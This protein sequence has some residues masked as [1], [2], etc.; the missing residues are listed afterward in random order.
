MR[1][2]D[3]VSWM[4]LSSSC[5]MQ[6]TRAQVHHASVIA[7]ATSSECSL[8]SVVMTSWRVA[9]TGCCGSSCLASIVTARI[10]SLVQV[11]CRG[12]V[13]PSPTKSTDRAIT[14]RRGRRSG[15]FRGPYG[16]L[17]GHLP[18]IRLAP[19]NV[20]IRAPTSGVTNDGTRSRG[21]TPKTRRPTKPTLKEG[22]RT[23]TD[24]TEVTQSPNKPRY[25]LR[26]R[27]HRLR[28]NSIRGRTLPPPPSKYSP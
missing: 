6:P 27:P 25:K 16:F 15:R 28:Y 19:T 1:T 24:V 10:V 13:V 7:A 26:R 3:S 5:S 23:Q 8:S 2:R 17:E 18:S 14:N 9:A 12:A 20:H 21:P 11:D 4:S 22:C